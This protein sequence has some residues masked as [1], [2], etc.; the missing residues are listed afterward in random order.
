MIRHL[1]DISPWRVPKSGHVTITK[2]ENLHID[3]RKNSLIPKMLLF[4]IFDKKTNELSRK[5]RFRTVASQALVNARPSRIDAISSS[6]HP[7]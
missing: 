4:S 1:A 6:I 7:S 5:I 2:I 3:T